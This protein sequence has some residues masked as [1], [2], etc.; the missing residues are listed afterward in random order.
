MQK[1]RNV[2]AGVDMG[3]THIRLC[4]QTAQGEALHCEKRRTADVISADGLVNGIKN[5]LQQQLTQHDAHCCGLVMGFPALVAKDKRTIIST[6]NLPLAADDLYNLAERLEAAL[7]CPVEFSRDVNLQ[8]SFDVQQNGLQ[9]QEVLA[10]YLGT[11]MGFAVWLNGGPWTGAH[12]V[13]GELGHIP[14]GDDAL[15]CAC[16]NPACLETVCSGIALKRWYEQQPRAYE[17]GELFVHAAREPFVQ[18]LLNHAARAIATS[19]NLFDPDAVILGGGVMDMS[20]FPREALLAMIKAHIRR[21]LPYQAVQFLAAS[22]STFNGAQG[23]AAL[24]RSRYLP[25]PV[26]APASAVSD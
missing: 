25:Q 18:Q 19:I 12:G 22:S 1:Q 23:A 24:A 13:A 8:L 14:L 9:E 5:L 10:A 20:G 2:V 11:G 16:G 15:T 6:P 17:L 26:A 4:L 7:G 3:A 21:P